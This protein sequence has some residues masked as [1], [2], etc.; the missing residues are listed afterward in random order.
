MSVEYP[1]QQPPTVGATALTALRRHPG[2]VAFSWD[3]G[4][5]RY[6]A[7]LELIGRIQG[8]FA[9]QGLRRGDR[10][11]I[12]SG[13]KAESW[14]SAVAAWASGMVITYLHQLGALADHLYQLQDS[15]ASTL[16]VDQ[17]KF[18]AR[19]AELAEQATGLR[20]VFTMGPA[21]FGRDL[22][23]AAEA[24]GCQRA[25]DVAVPGDLLWL[26][27]TGGTTGRPKGVQYRHRSVLGHTRAVLTDFEL[28]HRPRYLAA[29]PIT[30]V[31]GTKI[32]PVLTRGGTV[33][34]LDRFTPRQV[35]EVIQRERINTTLLVPTMIYA[36]LEDS[37]LDRTDLSSLELLL[38]GASSMSQQRLREG[39]ERIGRVFAQLYGQSECYPISYLSRDD[40]REGN[41]ALL[42][43]CGFP[44][45]GVQVAL[46]DQDG[47]A[48]P[49]GEPGE[50]CVRSQSAMDGYWNLPELTAEALRGGWLHTGDVG[51]RDE[52]GYL[53]IVDRKKD[54]I[55]SGGFNVFPREV[56][57]ALTAH[58]AVSSA[59]VYGK[60]DDRWG[61]AVTAAVILRP[62]ATVT[63]AELIAHVRELKGPVQAPKQLHIVDELP[64]TTLGKVDKVRLRNL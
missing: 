20:V 46:L 48:V 60:P 39:H 63:A 1:Q 10:V 53:T 16:V 41:P 49:E 33:H 30:H 18:T 50:I 24:I 47:H 8:V 58:P 21:D 29:A 64:T 51:R 9:A 6:G 36:I 3:G 52:R 13:N 61:E 42:A 17:T 45:H 35:L 7:A 57:D 28:P 5:L 25:R 4:E 55:I 32:L 23:A 31:A 54:M 62:G 11:A 12:L 56:E 59:A 40:H 19:G 34:L 27:Y 2:R 44:V 38:Y 43:S 26:N 14:L 15:G 37:A 22:R